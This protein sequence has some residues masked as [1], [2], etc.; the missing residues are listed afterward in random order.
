MAE[1]DELIGDW[2]RTRSTAD[3][4]AILDDNAVPSGTIFR[5]P[6]MLQNPHFK[7][8]SS[9]VEVVHPKW[10]AIHMQNV[11]PRLSETPGSVRSGAPERVGQHNAE[12]YGDIL[13]LDTAALAE[14]E[15]RRV[16]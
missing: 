1:L 15:S 7:A 14:L 10:G 2:T 6:D 4:A 13:G 12:V 9:L 16:V 11:C 8:R 3:V 5:A